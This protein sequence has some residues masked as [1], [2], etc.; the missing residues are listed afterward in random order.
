MSDPWIGV[1]ETSDG[2][3]ELDMNDADSWFSDPVMDPLALEY[4]DSE[5]DA[6]NPLARSHYDLL[7][8]CSDEADET[9]SDPDGDSTS[10]S[11]SEEEKESECSDDDSDDEDYDP[12]IYNMYVQQGNVSSIANAISI[13]FVA[14][15]MAGAYYASQV[16]ESNKVLDSRIQDLSNSV[17]ET[18]EVLR[19][20]YDFVQCRGNRT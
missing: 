11:S 12:N 3:S 9:V 14:L 13:G 20:F 19:M 8:S 17:E 18:A 1:E 6:S 10:S 15:A 4:S 16:E 7:K 5:D 2:V